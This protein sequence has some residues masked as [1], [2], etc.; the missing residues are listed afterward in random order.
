LHHVCATQARKPVR[1]ATKAAAAKLVDLCL[2]LD[3]PLN[4]AFDAAHAIRLIGHGLRE[5]TE[6]S[7]ARAVASAA[8]FTCQKLDALQQKWHD[9]LK[10]TAWAAS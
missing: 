4:E 6:E 7:E 2:D 10:A 8:W 5:F 1:R 3:D 9:L